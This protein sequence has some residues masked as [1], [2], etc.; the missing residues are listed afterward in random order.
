[1]RL[2]SKKGPSISLTPLKTNVTESTSTH[3]VRLEVAT[4]LKRDAV[5]SGA[6]V[7]DAARGMFGLGR[8][9]GKAAPAEPP[10][11]S[12]P[13]VF[14]DEDSGALRVVYRELAVRFARKVPR[15]T[16][17]KILASKGFAIRRENPFVRDQYIVYHPGRKYD[18]EELLEIANQWTELDEVL[19]AT[20][21][22]VSQYWRQAAPPSI[23]TAQWHLR[24]K[25]TGGAKKGE[26]V[27]ALAAWKITRG[28][29]S[30]VVAVLDDGVDIDHP[31]LAS[32]IWSNPDPGAPDQNGR[33]FF[34]AQDNPGHYDPRPKLFRFPFDQMTGNDI[35][36]TPCA[37]V[38]AAPG[39][40][41]GASGMAP[42]CRVLPVKVFHADELAADENVANAIRYAARHAQ[43][44]SCSWSGGFSSDLQQA[45]ED[46]ATDGR[47]GRGTLAFFAAG[48]E[49]G[50]P[51]GYP[52]RDPN[53]I[54]VGA[55]T[56]KARLADYS[57]VGKSIAFVAPS[58]GGVRG[59]YTTDVAHPNRGFNIGVA[60]AGGADGL[61]TNDFGGTSSATPLAAGI[62]ALVLSVRPKL[63]AT[64]VRELM[65]QTCDKIGSGYDANGH[66][67]RFGYGRVNAAKAVTA[68][69]DL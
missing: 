2:L 46:I 61:H 69:K 3:A 42:N 24:N 12:P 65:Q 39:L 19:F 38:I 47:D 63:E 41:G 48:N 7:A 54:A 30:I 15:E 59:I 55:S 5:S 45:L 13:T 33:D 32:R 68:A 51:V 29:K 43:I 27:G 31:K 21:N 52:A 58:S 11:G 4:S 10:K 25:G 1:M 8:R 44:L 35:H 49:Y 67:P 60:Q 6:L 57:N 40:K 26:D 64:A 22:F 17:K 18:G 14:R 28:K 16:R 62:A 23:L 50:S 56:D 37:G 66:S 53:A 20:P 34:L 9:A 36:G